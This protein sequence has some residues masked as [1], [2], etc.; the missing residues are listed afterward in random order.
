MDEILDQTEPPTSCSS[1]RTR[2]SIRWADGTT[3]TIRI[4]GWHAPGPAVGSAPLLNHVFQTFLQPHLDLFIGDFHM[5]GLDS[6]GVP[7]A[8]PMTLRRTNA[9]T[10]ITPLGDVPH[11]EGLDLVYAGAMLTAAGAGVGGVALGR[12]QVS[13]IPFPPMMDHDY[14]HR[15]SD[16]RTVMVEIKGL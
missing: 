3:R 11:A 9:S 10:T 12:A 1:T 8:T 2:R 13:V 7:I 5:T 15:L 14:M 4:A 16:H 6:G